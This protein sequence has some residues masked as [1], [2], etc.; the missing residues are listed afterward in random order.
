MII[1]GGWWYR[2][3]LASLILAAWTV[4]APLSEA[5]TLRPNQP[6]QQTRR[7]GQHEK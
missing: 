1:R 2:G 4:Q 6:S 5:Q 7:L 3:A